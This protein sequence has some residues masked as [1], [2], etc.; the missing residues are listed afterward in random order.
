MII[1]SVNHRNSNQ[2]LQL[3]YVFTCSLALFKIHSA[4]DEVEIVILE[5]LSCAKSESCS[6]QLQEYLGSLLYLGIVY[7]IGCRKYC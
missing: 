7:Y 1:Q 3:D 5:R 6:T 2:L 4:L